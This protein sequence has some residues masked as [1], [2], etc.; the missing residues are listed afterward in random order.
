MTAADGQILNLLGVN[1]LA[2]FRL[3]GLDGR[4]F[5]GDDD[6]LILRGDSQ[7]DVHGCGLTDGEHD[8]FVNGGGES[9]EG[10]GELVGV[11]RQVGNDV[12][13]GIVGGGAIDRIGGGIAQGEA[14]VLHGAA[15]FVVHRAVQLGDGDLSERGAGA[16]EEQCNNKDPKQHRTCAHGS[17]L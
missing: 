11:R 2:D 16:S 12:E 14:G 10:D 8:A 9:G 15:T 3:G 5:G 7:I 17:P 13:A 6:L 4:D 1:H